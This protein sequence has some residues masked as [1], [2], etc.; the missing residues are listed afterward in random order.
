VTSV[1]T[2]LVAAGLPAHLL[3]GVNYS[4]NS[5]LA[6][7]FPNEWEL[8]GRWT[9]I[10]EDYGAPLDLGAQIDYNNAAR[11]MD[12]ELSAARRAGPVRLLA[13]GRALANPEKRG[14]ARYAVAGGAVV[15]VGTYVALTGDVA[16][17]TNRTPDERVAWSAGLHLALPLTPHT[18]SLQATNTLVTTLQGASRGTRDVRYG[19]EFTIPLTLRRYFGRRAKQ[20]PPTVTTVPAA[21]DSARVPPP[22]A[23]KVD[24][25]I[26]ADTAAPSDSARAATPSS[27]AAA[28]VTKPAAPRAAAA[29]RPAP[30]AR[31][32]R[33]RI[34]NVA[35]LQTRLEITAGTTVEWT[36]ADPLAHSVTAVDRSFDSG[37]IQ[38]GRSFR[39]TFT[40][41][42][43]YAFFCMP[44]P[45]MQGV[46]VVRAP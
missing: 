24:T 43:S 36:N 45:F 26:V 33:T 34:K 21:P 35:Y 11:G 46:V 1:P 5:T 15:R 19:F 29:A 6:A 30:A 4:T 25:I 22:S 9:P 3:A 17:L 13:A 8:L 39:H 31:T 28:P 42:G 7:G 23:P 2:F 12:A 37:L 10:A 20:P 18:L 14:N 38:P 16:T 44:H 40:K 41:P 32:I 27:P